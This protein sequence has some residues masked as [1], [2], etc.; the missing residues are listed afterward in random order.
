[1][2]ETCGPVCVSLPENNRI[3]TIGMPMSGVTAGIADDGELC[4][5]GHLVCR[6]YHQPSRC[7]RRADRRRL[8]AHRRSGDI[9]EDWLSFDTAASKDRSS[10]R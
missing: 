8:A 3:G 10:N 7:D 4:V 6:G 5:R 2:T 9:D 1:M